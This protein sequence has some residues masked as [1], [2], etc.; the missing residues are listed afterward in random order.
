MAIESPLFL[1]G[2]GFNADASAEAGPVGVPSTYPMVNDL[3]G[4]SFGLANVPAGRSI[5]DLFAE[6]IAAREQ[7]PVD[8]LSETLMQADFFI[9]GRLKDPAITSSYRRF[10]E[11]F[12]RSHFLTFNYD[13]LLEII[14][15]KLGRWRPEDGYGVPVHAERHPTAAGRPRRSQNLVL[16]LHGS[17]CV[18]T[19]KFQ[20]HWASSRRSHL[21]TIQR[22]EKPLFA[23]DADSIGGLFPG[24][25][26]VLLPDGYHRLEERIVAPV[27]SKAVG[28]RQDFI[29]N[30]Y[31]HA[32]RLLCDCQRAVAIGYSFNPHD[33]DSFHPLL[34]A[35]AMNPK[36]SL[37]LVSPSASKIEGQ[38]A[39]QYPGLQVKACQATFREW[40]AS[41]FDQT[42]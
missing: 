4:I 3:A 41:G 8:R 16:H 32:K 23:F 30:V 35:L 31:D 25:K 27:P 7:A 21:G 36:A 11:Q 37:L 33:H 42:T 1:V 24:Y 29:G 13:S 6:A 18:Y 9:G 19:S 20:V 14:L 15:F 2:A 38:L 39:A 22:R 10:V 28:R 5:E 40:V 26:R 12:P 17:L 34:Q